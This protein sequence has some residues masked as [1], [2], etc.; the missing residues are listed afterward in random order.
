MLRSRKTT[1]FT[2]VEILCVVVIL[3]IAAGIIIPQLGTRDD[4]KAA[5]AA[6]MLISDFMYA[7]NLAISRQRPHYIQFVDQQYTILSRDTDTSPLVAILHPINKNS[8]V[9]S[10]DGATVG[11]DDVKIDSID[12][13]GATI[14]GFDEL[15]SP[16][17]YDGVTV[18]PL[19]SAAKITLKCG[20]VS[21]TASIEPFTGEASVQ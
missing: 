4:L 1:G 16:F 8:Y 9:V 6:R 7:Q 11:I 20:E 18:T 3:G 15:G 10:F 2:L 17:T 12:F 5:A 21:L 13:G 14:I 19:A